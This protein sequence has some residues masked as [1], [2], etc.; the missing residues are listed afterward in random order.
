ML[1]NAIGRTLGTLLGA[2]YVLFGL[3]VWAM[4]GILVWGICS[5]VIH[6]ILRGLGLAQ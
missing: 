2:L 4:S 1:W 5:A 6:A 3:V